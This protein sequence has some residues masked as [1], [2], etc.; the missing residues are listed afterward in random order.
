MSTKRSLR[1]SIG[2][3][4]MGVVIVWGICY[5]FFDIQVSLRVERISPDKPIVETIK[6]VFDKTLTITPESYVEEEDIIND[7]NN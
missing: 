5:V 7:S 1:L 4:L 6:D 2:D 3:F